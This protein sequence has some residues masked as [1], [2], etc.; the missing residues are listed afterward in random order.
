MISYVL[1]WAVVVFALGTLFVIRY[2][3]SGFFQVSTVFDGKS[4]WIN[5]FLP[6][7]RTTQPGMQSEGWVGQRVTDDPTYFTARIPGPYERVNVKLE[8]RPVHQPLLEFGLVRDAAGNDLDLQPL[9]SESLESSA[10]R[11]VETKD[12]TGFVRAANKDSRLLA[13]TADGLAVWDATTTYPALQDPAGD[14]RVTPVSLRGSHDFY[15]VPAGG[16]VRMIFGIQ[17][18]NRTEGSDNAVFRI[19]KG[20][21]EI[22]RRVFGAS[23]SQERRMGKTSFHDIVVKDAE[24]G[25][26]RISFVAPDDV[27]LREIRTTSARW[28]VGPRLYF[29]DVVGYATSTFAGRALTDSRHIVAETF[30]VEG[31]QKI[32]FGSTAF[33]VRKTHEATRADRADG[34]GSARILAPNG[35]VRI[36]GDGLFALRDDAFFVPRPRRWGDRTN[37]ELESIDG[38]LT[39]YHRPEKLEDGWYRAE[40]SWPIDSSLERLRFV[41]SAP[42][43]AAR[44]GGV[45]IR[46]VELTYQRPAVSREDWWK[47]MKTEL[48]NAWKRL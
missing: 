44:A 34:A 40:F 20:D 47:T 3:S 33:S 1:P 39:S 37:P 18:A 7:E 29:G 16:E 4:A 19:F 32:Q 24:P 35:D 15:V 27:F 8:F 46:N 5:P 30:H 6:A 23:G 48:S 41:L 14:E 2:P 25:V 42:G 26:Y 43:I 36:V 22:S 10:W 28:M 9:F 45:D 21:E 13:E 12:V 17:A 11:R 31:V 38:V